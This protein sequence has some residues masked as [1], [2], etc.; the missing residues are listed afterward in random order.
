M[1]SI[2]VYNMFIPLF[3]PP[4]DLNEHWKLYKPILEY[5]LQKG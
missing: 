3:T 2:D 4:F 1:L 5:G